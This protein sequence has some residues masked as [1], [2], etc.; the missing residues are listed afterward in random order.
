[1]TLKKRIV[2]SVSLTYSLVFGIVSLTVFML[3]SK[4]R[5]DEFL[6]RLKAKAFTTGRLL[7]EVKEVDNQ[8][9]KLIDKNT[10][11]KLFNEK[12]VVFNDSNK[13]V[14]SSVDDLNIN[15]TKKD[16]IDLNQLGYFCRVEK[17][18]DLIG[19][20]YKFQNHQYYIFVSAKDQFGLSKLSYLFYLLLFSYLGST[21]I[22]WIVSVLLIDRLIKPLEKFESQITEIS[23]NKLNETLPL[24]RTEDEIFRLTLAFNNLLKRLQ[25]SF[26]LQREF[27]S[28]VSH[29]LKT[30]LTRMAFQIENV[31]KFEKIETKQL[32]DLLTNIYQL[33][34]MINNL[35][36]ITKMDRSMIEVE[37]K[38]ERIDEII[39]RSYKYTKVNFPEFSIKFQMELNEESELEPEINVLPGLIDIV[40]RNLMK[41]A[42]LY[43]FNRKAEIILKQNLEFI[44]IR[45]LNDGKLLDAAEISTLFD[46]FKRGANSSG[47][48]G[49]GL[50]LR[51]VQNIL[52]LHHATIQYETYNEQLNQFIVRFDLTYN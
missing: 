5:Q 24:S 40:F 32:K 45:M 18:N 52:E 37:K 3:F 29:E 33:N 25:D 19:I 26:K 10:I 21:V 11:N 27:T 1:M 20:L 12:T 16:F 15:Y 44:E 30:P 41:N 51:I 42:Y 14:Y 6:E 34:D 39:F 2:I 35:L 8:L 38:T 49:S 23:I 47:K 48:S 43:S 36:L 22:V 28:S 46:A 31:L 50:G 13:I 17:E 4:F 7:I 9:L